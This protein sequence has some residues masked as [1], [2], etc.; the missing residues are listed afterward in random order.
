MFANSASVCK[1]NFSLQ[2]QLLLAKSSFLTFVVLTGMHRVVLNYAVFVCMMLNI[3]LS[4]K[5]EISSFL[6]KQCRHR[7]G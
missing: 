3:G 1:L 2:T 5:L 7:K 6:D 4:N